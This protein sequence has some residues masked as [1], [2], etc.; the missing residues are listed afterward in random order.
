MRKN[1]IYTVSIVRRDVLGHKYH[2]NMLPT[3]N[4]I[5]YYINN[6]PEH[7]SA[8]AIAANSGRGNHHHDKA[9]YA[10]IQEVDDTLREEKYCFLVHRGS[11]ALDEECLG[12]KSHRPGYVTAWIVTSDAQDPNN[13]K[14]FVCMFD[15]SFLCKRRRSLED[16]KVLP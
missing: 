15:N 8:I 1:N 7:S 5:S 12:P 2:T 16:L 9:I 10:T 6:N 4:L 13:P 11:L 14:N 3:F